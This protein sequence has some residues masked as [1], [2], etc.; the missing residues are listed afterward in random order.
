MDGELDTNVYWC[1]KIFSADLFKRHI[2]QRDKQIKR[3][4][5]NKNIQQRCCNERRHGEVD[6]KIVETFSNECVYRAGAGHDDNQRA[7]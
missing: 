5:Q 3:R 7:Q 6:V 1:E 2:S 4:V